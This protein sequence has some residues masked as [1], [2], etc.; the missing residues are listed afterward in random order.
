MSAVGVMLAAAPAAVAATAL[1]FNV[2]VRGNFT[3]TSSDVEGRLAAGGNISVGAY[4]IGLL[5]PAPAGSYAAVAGGSFTGNY[6]TAYGNVL[7]TSFSG[8]FSFDRD[9][10]SDTATDGGP[11]TYAGGGVSPININAEL[12]KLAT[13]SGKLRTNAAGFA[14]GTA[15]YQWN[16]YFLT[17]TDASVNLFQL[18]GALLGG[19]NPFYGM[20]VNVPTNSTVI[21]NIS[22]GATTGSPITLSSAGVSGVG[23]ANLLYNFYEAQGVNINTAYGTVLAPDADIVTSSGVIQG[24]V[25]AD[26]FFGNTQVNMVRLN[27]GST[28]FDSSTPEPATWAM[29]VGGFF[30]L[31]SAMRRRLRDRMWLTRPS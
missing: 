3:A 6:G 17:G 1:D 12:N 9:G 10:G 5:D 8:P 28:I 23:F 13:A 4:S 31:G 30:M 16:Q 29:L 21:L 20:V 25:F 27:R 22:G 15:T 26:S 14:Q 7:A 11:V 18:D 19:A 2:V 24:Q